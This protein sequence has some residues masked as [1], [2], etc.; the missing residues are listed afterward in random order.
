M[1]RVAKTR[2][3]KQ[4]WEIELQQWLRPFVE[5][6]G[7]KRRARWA[8]A[9]VRGLILPGERKSIEPIAKRVAP[10]D[11][12]QLHHFVSTSPWAAE[13]LQDVLVRKA[14][15]LVGGGVLIIDDTGLVKK[16]D[17]SVGVGHQYCG[18][19]GKNAN[20]QALVSLTLARDEVPVAV[21]LRLFLPKQWTDNPKRCAAAG[22]PKTIAFQTKWQISLSEID[23]VSKAGA[24]F[25]LVCADAGYGACAGFRAGLDERDLLWAVG[26]NFNQHVYALDTELIVAKPSKKGRPRKNPRVSKPSM[27][28]KDFIEA[29]GA[30]AFTNI[31]WR[32]GSKGVLRC[33]F[34]AARVLVADGREVT[35]GIHL[36]GRQAWVVCE[37]RDSGEQKYYLT[38]HGPT[39]SLKTLAKAIKARW[40]CEQAHQQL[41]EEL[42]LDHFEGR[43]WN[44]LNHHALFSMMAFCFLQHLRLQEKKRR[45][46]PVRPRSHLSLAS[47]SE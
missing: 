40:V 31:S 11:L 4:S 27:S 16:G 42:G 2:R 7:D 17:Q 45:A 22:V 18:Q 44:G 19:L 25:K 33:E 41:K 29:L 28:A 9:Y 24:T 6:L 35:G 37:R 47:D 15:K 20:S 14:Q 43:S 12:Q 46:P 30:K 8:P 10:A 3:N 36:P 39:A 1:E 34:A 32:R 38:N 5:E 13:P 26:I 23:R 21:G